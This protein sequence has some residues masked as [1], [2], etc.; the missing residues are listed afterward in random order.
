[1]ADARKG[2]DWFERSGE[3]ADQPEDGAADLPDPGRALHLAYARCFSTPDGEKVLTHL[4]AL[5]LE[6]TFGPDTPNRMLRHGEG[7]RQLVAYVLAQ[8]ERGR[9]G[10]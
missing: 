6:R 5:T 9:A 10:G 8:I 2:W 7:Q 1:M 4:R 3:H